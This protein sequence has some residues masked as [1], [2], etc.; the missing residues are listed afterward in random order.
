MQKLIKQ[1]K[2]RWFP[3]VKSLQSFAK[4]KALI[5]FLSEE[6]SNNCFKNRKSVHAG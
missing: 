1:E 2:L 5:K 4:K 3:I 6:E